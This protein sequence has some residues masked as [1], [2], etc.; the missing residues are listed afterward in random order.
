MAKFRIEVQFDESTSD[1]PY[2]E[3]WTNADLLIAVG[4]DHLTRHQVKARLSEGG[5]RKV[6][7]VHGPVSGLADWFIENWSYI[8]WETQTPFKRSGQQGQNQ[9]RPA[10]PG[11]KEAAI[12]WDGYFNGMNDKYMNEYDREPWLEKIAD[13]QHRHLLG[14]A[15]SDLAIPS[16]VCVPEG[17][18]IL[19]SV[20]RLS[21][22]GIKFLG[23]DDSQRILTQYAID[24]RNFRSSVSSFVDS[25]IKHIG[26]EGK[27]KTMYNW[28]KRRWKD[29]KD[30]ESSPSRQLELMIG[31]VGANRVEDLRKYDPAMAEGLH[32][33]LLDCRSVENFRELSPV[34]DVLGQFIGRDN[35]SSLS[36][37][38]ASWEQI[39][40]RSVGATDPDYI[41]GYQLAQKVRRELKLGDRP[42]T[43][44]NTT[45][46]RLDVAVEA[47]RNIGLFRAAA[48]AI[49]GNRAHIVPSSSDNRM[50]YKPSHNFY[51]ISALGRLLWEASGSTG[52][53]ICVAQGDYS[54]VSES[55][56][57]NA[58]AA[59][60]LLPQRTVLGIDADS[61][62]LRELATQYGISS[63]AAKL[64]C[65]DIE[66]LSRTV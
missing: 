10:F 44:V 32:Q 12:Q 37:E 63:E 29:A 3:D 51:V 9:T 36:G 60:F 4:D 45:L 43:N 30:Y 2:P 48:C 62:K 13:W 15:N 14:H 57:A 58:F 21:P 56:R 6:N 8:N 7:F 17:E 38:R 31:A 42:I 34:E 22:G 50:Q 39:S 35:T 66:R 64:H 23:P 25:I 65:Q 24:K 33:L 41:Q 54:M 49:K 19:L 40:R 46:N 59:E 20:D 55:R 16:I 26:L 53:T 47:D 18:K 61:P 52:N 27:H 1:S 11:A 28:M 5:N